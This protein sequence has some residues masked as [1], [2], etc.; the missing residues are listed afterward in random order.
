MLPKKIRFNLFERMSVKTMRYVSA[1]PSREAEGLVARI[2]D[3][4][5]EDFFIN[6][7]LTSHSKV[8][9]LMAGV[10]TWGRESI[11]VSD[12][13]DRT[14]KEAMTAV[15]S[16]INECPYC[17]DML[18]SL[19]NGGGKQEAASRIFSQSE[20]QITD[21]TLRKRLAW[22]KAVASP[23]AE[24]PRETPFSPEALPEAIGALFAM[25]HINRFSHVVMDGS[26]VTAPLGLHKVKEAALRLFGSELKTTTERPIEP[27]RALD[28]LPPAPL[29]EDLTWAK[30]N[31]RIADAFSRWA[32]VIARETPKVVSPQVQD[33]VHSNLQSWQGEIMPISRSW[34]DD[35]TE[36]LTGQ[37]L[38]IAR[39][40]LVVAKAS[41]QVDD[42]L[43]EAV[44]GEDKDET[45]LIR[46]LAWAAFS[47][48]RRLAQRI[49]A[50][51]GQSTSSAVPAA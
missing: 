50:T 26:P 39:L 44:L 9:D 37:D 20:E 45:R 18:I 32:A 4:I 7:S 10:W 40:T 5:A 21:A 38:A 48:A 46:V 25:S 51:A 12:Y 43:V 17:G 16:Q 29:P 27:G 6:G 24:P 35:E 49:A 42:A 2:Y 8:P 28:L 13:L 11:L 33:L 41:Y 22:V 3:M 1:V 19:V 23:G 15:L 34:V 30:P 14:T 31:P 36:G 47:A